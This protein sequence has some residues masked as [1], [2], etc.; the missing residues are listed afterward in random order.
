MK[1]EVASASMVAAPFRGPVAQVQNLKGVFEFEND[2]AWFKNVRV[3][4]PG[5]RVVA[6]GRYYPKQDNLKIRMQARPGA[7]SDF[8]WVYPDFPE[9]GGGPIDFA[10]SW[11]NGVDTYEL[12]NFDFTVGRSNVAG[13]ST[14]HRP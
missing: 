1:V 8:R 11:W 3:K 5:S 14:I 7:F 10:M 4:L 6:E 9:T 12:K 13:N 2:S